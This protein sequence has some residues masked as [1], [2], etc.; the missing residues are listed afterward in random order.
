MLESEKRILLALS[1][2]LFR[3]KDIAEKAG[4]LPTNANKTLESLRQQGLV[5]WICRGC[6]NINADGF[7]TLEDIKK[8]S[9]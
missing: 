8:C 7:K 2:G 4:V 6:W 5:D 9:E 3:P 1:T